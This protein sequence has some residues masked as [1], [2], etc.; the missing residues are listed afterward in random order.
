MGKIEVKETRDLLESLALGSNAPRRATPWQKLKTAWA[1]VL[2]I[3][4]PTLPISG[5]CSSCWAQLELV[6]DWLLTK[7]DDAMVQGV[8]FWRC[9]KCRSGASTRY[10]YPQ[11]PD[12]DWWLD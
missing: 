5:Y 2:N 12:Y 7:S 3:L 11:P 10:A 9:P 8:R 6:D 4:M 1:R